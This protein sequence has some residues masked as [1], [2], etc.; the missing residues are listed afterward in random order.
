MI[1]KAMPYSGCPFYILELLFQTILNSMT[2]ITQ[3]LN[4]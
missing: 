4:I 1:C 2:Q 3:S